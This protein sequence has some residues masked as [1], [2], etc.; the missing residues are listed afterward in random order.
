VKGF[1]L[2][3]C[4][5][6]TIGLTG[7]TAQQIQAIEND[8]HKVNSDVTNAVVA[9]ENNEGP[10]DQDIAKAE[11]LIGALGP[12]AAVLQKAV[13]DVQAAWTAFKSHQGSIDQ[14]LQALAVIDQLTAPDANK[15]VVARTVRKK[16]PN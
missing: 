1:A 3:A 5:A 2:A 14:V 8:L 16:A 9:V 12:K 10:I 13:A 7:C 4:A 6:L 11:A 15:P